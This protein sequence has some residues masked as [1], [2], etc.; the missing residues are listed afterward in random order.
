MTD[1]PYR[2][3]IVDDERA[4][5]LGL[6]AMLA[7][8]PEV[9]VISEASSGIQAGM[10]IEKHHPDLVFLDIQMPDRDG[11][12]MLTGLPADQRPAVVFVTAHA[13]H[14][15]HAFGMNAV[16]YLIKP[17]HRDRLA[18]AVRRA[19]RFLRGAALESANI[20][21]PRRLV[22][23]DGQQM[24]FVDP[25]DVRWFEVSGNYVRLAVNGRFLWLRQTLGA[26][27]AGLDA[28][29]FVRINR[30]VVVNLRHVERVRRTRGGQFE[31]RMIGGLAL[32]A[33]R[34]YGREVRLALGE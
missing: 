8:H 3:L 25:S 23:R 26:V 5:R 15:L 4:A 33:S 21:R 22:A 17:F 6:R 31:F 19:V 18:A 29:T 13:Q 20:P 10:A 11:F 32:R 16:D 7:A 14:A 34:R 30:S 28:T 9:E 27:A 24:V 1:Q 2:A 12:A